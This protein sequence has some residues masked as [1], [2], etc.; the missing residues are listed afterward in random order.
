[1]PGFKLIVVTQVRKLEELLCWFHVFFTPEG[2]QLGVDTHYF[3][4]WTVVPGSSV[5][6][7][8]GNSLWNLKTNIPVRHHC[9][10]HITLVYTRV[11]KKVLVAVY[12]W[13]YLDIPVYTL[14]CIYYALLLK[15]NPQHFFHSI[16]L[17]S[18]LGSSL[19]MALLWMLELGLCAHML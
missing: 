18:F 14:E 12:R 11:K 3:F 5:C 10:Q 6:F 19:G 8:E 17:P 16:L 13:N 15:R 2:L 7:P 4:V 9:L 1:M